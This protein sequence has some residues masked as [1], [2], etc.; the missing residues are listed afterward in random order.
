MLA[1]ID[2]SESKENLIKFLSD[3][4]QALEQTFTKYTPLQEDVGHCIQELSLISKDK[5]A[6]AI[7]NSILLALS[8]LYHTLESSHNPFDIPVLSSVIDKTLPSAAS[9]PAKTF[10]EKLRDTLDSDSSSSP[11]SDSDSDSERSHI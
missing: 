8:D 10:R 11:S 3:F 2:T 7:K 6:G 5:T 1:R 9:N 4:S